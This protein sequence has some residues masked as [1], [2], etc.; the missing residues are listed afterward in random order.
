MHNA[1]INNLHLAALFAGC[2]SEISGCHVYMA[3]WSHLYHLAGH[4]GNAPLICKC[5]H[6]VWWAAQSS[7]CPHHVLKRASPGTDSG[8]CLS[9]RELLPQNPPACSSAED[10]Q[11]LGHSWCC[12]SPLGSLQAT[13][14]KE[15]KIK[16]L[17][18]HNM[19]EQIVLHVK[20]ASKAVQSTQSPPPK[21][22]T[23]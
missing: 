15:E 21:V 11:G 18:L 3:W 4:S 9:A 17:T 23:H 5:T 19:L 13:L 16:A 12:R 14:D 1:F 20:A 10:G 8:A 7:V 2:P 22:C 6:W